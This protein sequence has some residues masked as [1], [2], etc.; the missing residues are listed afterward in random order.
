MTGAKQIELVERQI[1]KFRAGQA[2]SLK[3]PYCGSESI[4]PEFCCAEIS[5]CAAAILHREITQDLLDKAARIREIA[6]SN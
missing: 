6:M 1:Q 2:D 5:Q 3:C 4:P